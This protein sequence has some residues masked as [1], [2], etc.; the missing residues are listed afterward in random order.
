MK[1][2][3][4]GLYFGVLVSLLV[5]AVPSEAGIFTDL[6]AFSGSLTDGAA[7]NGVALN[8]GQLYGSTAQGGAFNGGMVYTLA[9]NGAGFASIHDFANSPDGSSPNEVLQVADM[10]FGTTYVG[11]TNSAGTIYKLNTNGSGYVILR[12][13]GNSPDPVYP[14]AGLVM[15]GNMLYGTSSSGGANGQG[16]VFKVD[17]NGA[18]FAVLHDFTNNPDGANPQGRLLLNGSTLYGTTQGGGSNSVGTIFKVNTDGT[19]YAVLWHFAYAPA[20]TLPQVGLIYDNST[21]Y[22]VS[23]SGGTANSGTVFRIGLNGTGF[24]II[25]SFTNNEG[26]SPQGVLTLKNSL[27]YGTASSGGPLTNGIVFQ[28]ATNGA[29]FTVLKNFTNELTGLNPAGPLALDGTTIY[30]VAYAG[31]PNSGANGGGTVYRLVLA[32]V[33]TTQ[34]QNQTTTNGYPASFSVVAVD[35]FPLTY[36]WYYNTSTLLGGQT[37]STLNLASVTGGNAGAYSVVITDNANS[38]TSSPALLT[39]LS[40][41]TITGQPQS[42]NRT[43]GDSA[44]FTVTATSNAGGPTYQ[45]YFNTNTLLSGQ[46]GASLN[47]TGVTN[48]N[49]GAYTVVVGNNIGSV[50]SSPALLTVIFPPPTITAQPQSLN[51][52]NGNPSTFSVTA[53]TAGGILLYQWYFNT[54][55]VIPGQ[56]NSTYTIPVT[57][58][59]NAGVYTVAVANNG[60]SVTSSPATLT[61]STNSKPIISAQTPNQIVT[62]GDVVNISVTA[63]GLG[64]LR[65][66]W[67]T[68]SAAS[69]GNPIGNPIISR[70]NALVSFTANTNFHYYFTVIVTNSLGKATSSPALL[71]IISS[72]VIAS[73]PQP[74]TVAAGSPA[75]FTVIAL[76]AS[77]SYQWY[78]NSV[79]TAIGTA[80]PTQTGSTYSFTATTNANGKYYS[81]VVT[82]LYGRAT[83]S[84]ALLTVSTLPTITIQPLPG[85]VTNG[86]SLTFTSGA[87]GPGPLSYQWLLNT[88]VLVPDATNTTLTVTESNQPGYYAMKAANSFG[89]V[90][91]NPALL[92]IISLPYITLQ[93]LGATITNGSPVTFTSSAAGLGTLGYQWLFQN[94]QLIPGATSTSLS[95]ATANQPGS[96]AMKV[97]NSYGAATSSPALLNVVGQPIMLS[98]VFDPASGSYAFSY[99]NLAGSTN[100][101]LATTNLADPSAWQAIATNTMATN[102]LWQFTDLNTARTNNLRLYRFSSP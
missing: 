2:Y 97:T 102:G 98:S 20:A 67:Y 24:T 4:L 82:N 94:T 90:T 36:Q 78:S 66:Q 89:S 41:P 8:N 92:T 21:L 34:P 77:L 30:G 19:G 10:I 6:H 51:V 50:T 79:N 59:N 76:G 12:S 48:G 100:R 47:L 99:V 7:P 29:N 18:N 86:S 5:A 31:G 11:G 13:F 26:L 64:P 88:N 23:L 46:T 62:N 17:T 49:A 42:L 87:A 25:H 27:L 74:A 44:T 83:S 70:T 85:L 84:P 32:P 58:T 9:T 15:S 68:N 75:T 37:G 63:S 38:V 33:I 80:L 52:T 69:L 39:V 35:E 53:T 61:V 81:V 71:T 45:W 101:L 16:T 96:Y 3:N 60:G 91:S 43:N 65:Y 95:F 55:T 22:G 56:T 28:L 54:N 1:K 93:P 57:F 72:P 14:H 73:N 40:V